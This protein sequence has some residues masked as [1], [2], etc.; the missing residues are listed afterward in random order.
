MQYL[1]LSKLK[2]ESQR[3]KEPKWLKNKRLYAWEQFKKRDYSKDKHHFDPEFPLQK[4]HLAE[5][6]RSQLSPLAK[7]LEQKGV[8]W[9]NFP[10]TIREHPELLKEYFFTK[11]VQI[12]EEKLI[13]LHAAF[14]NQGLMLFVP[15]N[16]SLTIP[17]DT[18]FF[19]GAKNKAVFRHFLLIIGENSKVDFFHESQSSQQREKCYTSEVME[20]YL[21]P[22]ASLNL[23]NIQNIGK[24][25]HYFIKA[26]ALLEK[27][28]KLNWTVLTKG[29]PLKKSL[30]DTVLL[31]EKAESK[32]Q[33]ILLGQKEEKIDFSFQQDNR[34]R[35]TK[36]SLLIKGIVQ[37]Q[38]HV[39]IRGLVKI[40]P[41]AQ[42][43]NAYFTGRG[44]ILNEKARFNIIPSLE[45]EANDVQAG[46]AASVS[47]INEEE[48]FYLKSR[49]LN[50]KQASQ[51]ISEGFF[52][53]VINCNPNRR[54][55]KKITNSLNKSLTY[56]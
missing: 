13:A 47:Q 26:R 39:M 49:G 38:A 5:I 22:K 2:S 21:K 44:L 54:I 3:L 24:T 42:N 32:N 20:V 16:L 9:K 56:V 14:V 48:L 27:E 4:M 17:F 28:S 18:K 19:G 25:E 37:D 7:N 12:Q 45:I 6:A 35:N 36:G 8:I 30:F 11:C 10:Q 1:T 53:D 55:Q 43:S 46:H 52:Q 31:K 33:A 23:V 51:M 50:E 15:K 29:A 40:R 34:S 41:K